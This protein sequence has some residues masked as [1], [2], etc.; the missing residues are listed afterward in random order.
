M[1]RLH[2]GARGDRGEL[3]IGDRVVATTASAALAIIRRRA[4]ARAPV[5]VR[6]GMSAPD[7]SRPPV[8]PPG[9]TTPARLLGFES[10][11]NP[12]ERP[13]CHVVL[14]LAAVL[15]ARPGRD[16][17]AAKP[18]DRVLRNGEIHTVD[19]RDSVREALAVRDGEIVYAGSDAGVRR[20]IG[21]AR[22]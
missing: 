4:S 11:S 13:L 2:A 1:V 15:R 8:V 5:G 3:H 7:P 14:A 6:G 10:N 17:A 20:Y 19:A 9:L 22:R 18:A 21:R 16:R 12:L